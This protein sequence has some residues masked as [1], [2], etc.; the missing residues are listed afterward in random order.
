MNLSLTDFYFNVLRLIE[1]PDRIASLP[2]Q[3]IERIHQEM[4]PV[5]EH[6]RQTF[7]KLAK[8]I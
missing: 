6:N 1:Y 4:L 5:F 2:L 8:N 7:T 3:D